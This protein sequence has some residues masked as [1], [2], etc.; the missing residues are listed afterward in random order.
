MKKFFS[1]VLAA[2]LGAIVLAAPAAAQTPQWSQFLGSPAHTNW[3]QDP[4]ITTAT[5]PRL[6]VKWM[7]HIFAADLGSPTVAYNS[8]LGT[9]VVYVGNERGD[10]F[11]INANTGQT[12]WEINLGLNVAERDTPAIGP[13]GAVWIGSNYDAYMYKLNGATGAIECSMQSPDREAVM[14]SPMIVQPKGSSSTN[15]YWAVIDQGVYGYI[16]STNEAT[17]ATNWQFEVQAGEWSTPAYGVDGAGEPL[18]MGGSASENGSNL[19]GGCTEYAYDANTGKQIWSQYLA[20]F[21][22]C[23]AD[24]GN[25]GD[26]SAPGNNGFA[27]GVE[28][29]ADDD[30]TEYGL[31]MNT[32]KPIW[33][34]NSYP[35]GY[36]AKEYQISTQALDGT[37]EIYGYYN[38]VNDLNAVT[39]T[40]NWNWPSQVGVDSSPLIIGPS[41]SEVVAFADI[42]GDFHVLNLS[43]GTQA[44]SFQ[45]AGYITASASDYNGVIYITSA[46]G[47]LYAFAPGGSNATFPT[48]GISAP[49]NGTTIAN[50]DGNLSLT[51]TASDNASVATVEVAVQQGGSSGPFW[52]SATSQWQASPYRNV[53]TLTSPGAKTTNWSFNVPIPASGNNYTVFANAINGTNLAAQPSVVSF[54][55]SPSLNE[56]TIKTSEFDV[57]PAATFNASGNAFKPGETVQFTLFGATVATAT[58]G[59][60]GNVPQTAIL[61]PSTAVFGPTSLTVTG[62]TSN[63]SASMQIYITN[64]WLQAGY[65]ALRGAQEPHDYVINH[66]IFAGENVVNPIWTFATGAA[67]NTSAVV[68]DG[69]AYIANDAGTVS[70]INYAFGSQVWQY[71]LPDGS[72][73]RSSPAI[74]DNAQLVFGSNDGNLNVISL[75]GTAVK[76]ISLGGQLD[77]VAYSNG[78]IVVGS[79]T[80]EIYS[81]ADPAWTTNWSVNVGAAPVVAPA[82]DGSQGLVFV[83]LPNGNVEALSSST[84]ASKWTASP[85]GTLSGIAATGTELFVGSSNGVFA[86]NERTGAQLWTD[87]SGDGSAVTTIDAN[88][89]G[90][91]WGTAD[92]NLYD[93]N[94]TGNVYYFRRKTYV[95]A[96]VIGIAGAGTDEFGAYGIGD[97]GMLRANDG[98]WFY[99]S[100][101][102]YSTGPVILNGVIFQGDQNGNFTAFA[103]LNYVVAPQVRVRV[104]AAVIAI[105][106]TGQT[107]P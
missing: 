65:S 97:L 105:D 63:K 94:S 40:L 86:Y 33:T 67:V 45:T 56:P 39:G 55:V 36:T 69:I 20:T 30:G 89:G 85:G 38:G 79:S 50:P 100:G 43:S 58:V 107:C 24:I 75:T 13:D 34:F 17:C 66:T 74:D 15:V 93:A 29:V 44:Y 76:T 98:G 60:T 71:T 106:G 70:A 25:G 104:G 83:A 11:A 23:G 78:N 21:S 95:D 19:P 96:P 57:A 91:S 53:A 31:D 72:P 73:I 14:A 42:A 5:A 102:T 51:G 10:V 41:G 99:Q 4:A 1:I 82:V 32:G 46:D 81:I 48:Q 88:G 62:E 9:E 35:A 84:G 64:A 2:A 90:P 37:Q 8:T 12:I 27:D 87:P 52:N 28:Y 22:F 7:A 3:Q 49:S 77:N 80:G 61:V 68:Q 54:N 26:I 18:I 59:K 103:P 92:G 47:Y 101:S 16:T 6:G